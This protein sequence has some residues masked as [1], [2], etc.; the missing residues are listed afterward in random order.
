[1][2]PEELQIENQQQHHR[3]CLISPDLPDVLLTSQNCSQGC[4]C[5]YCHCVFKHA[6][7]DHQ[8]RYSHTYV[9]RNVSWCAHAVYR[10]EEHVI[11]LGVIDCAMSLIEI[12]ITHLEF[13]LDDIIIICVDLSKQPTSHAGQVSGFCN[14]CYFPLLC[15]FAVFGQA[16]TQKLALKIG[17]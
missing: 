4:A 10:K 9:H 3:N 14:E 16:C 5:V 8:N 12:M 17:F 7:G 11:V 1:M 13:G 15:K 2:K 6:A